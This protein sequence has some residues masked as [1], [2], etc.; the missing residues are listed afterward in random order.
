MFILLN[1]DSAGNVCKKQ[2]PRG[3]GF[4]GSSDKRII[5]K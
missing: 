5:K 4:E 1:E 2:G 3:Q